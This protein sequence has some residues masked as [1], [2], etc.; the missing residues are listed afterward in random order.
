MNTGVLNDHYKWGW[1]NDWYSTPSSPISKMQISFTSAGTSGSFHD[2]TI[3][4]AL[5]LAN[6][7]TK[8]LL[9]C[10][11][12]GI[13]S[14]VICLALKEAKIPFTAFTMRWLDNDSQVI[15]NDDVNY[16]VHF[17]KMH[18][19]SHLLHDACL[20]TFLLGMGSAIAERC[21]FQFY[22]LLTHVFIAN[23]FKESHTIIIGDGNVVFDSANGNLV[24]DIDPTIIQ[25]YFLE[26]DID[27]TAH[28]FKYTP[29]LLLAQINNETCLAFLDAHES[30]YSAYIH[31]SK[32]PYWSWRMFGSYVKPLIY[33]THWDGLLHRS[34]Q[35]G[36]ETYDDS[37]WK[38]QIHDLGGRKFGGTDNLIQIPAKEFLEFMKSPKGTERIWKA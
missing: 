27:G 28:F 20:E 1:G 11:S 37:Y 17:C 21:C 3:N 25:Q 13:D 5:A 2:E 8:P 4:A 32:T 26:E 33:Q 36:F 31:D 16:A 10:L 29:E 19:I 7:S 15:N 14:Q 30:L 38:K 12:G 18:N 6:K 35:H 9:V 34:K 24:V 22:R 23:E